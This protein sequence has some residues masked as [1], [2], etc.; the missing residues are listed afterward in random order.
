MVGWD[1]IRNR[2][3]VLT[4]HKTIIIIIIIIINVCY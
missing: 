1:G 2:L 4:R 3:N